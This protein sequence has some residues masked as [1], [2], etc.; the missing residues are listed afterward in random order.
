MA[1]DEQQHQPDTS[2]PSAGRKAEL[3]KQ[4]K[5]Q[6]SITPDSPYKDVVIRTLGEVQWIMTQRGWIGELDLSKGPEQAIANRVN[7]SGATMSDANL[8]GAILSGANLSE[9]NLNRAN[10]SG[11]DLLMANLSS[12]TLRETNLNKTYLGGVNLAEAI[13]YKADLTEAYLGGANLTRVTLRNANLS[14]VTLS[15]ANLTGSHLQDANLSEATLREAN[16]TGIILR[17]AILN[18]VD[19]T[20]SLMDSETVLDGI[21]ID[22]HTKVFGVRWNGAPLD[23]IKW[24]QASLLGDE[25]T[26]EE[27]AVKTANERVTAY[28]NAARAYHGLSVALRGQGLA[29]VASKYRLREL[30]MERKA[31]RYDRN[32]GGWI[33]NMILGV[34]AGYGEK[35][36]RIFISYLVVVLSFAT[37]YFGVTHLVETGLSRLTWDESLVLSLTSFHGRG[38]FPG[39]LSLGD[40]V[41]RI[42]ALEAVIGLFIELILIAT[43][44]RRFLGD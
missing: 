42:A 26:T 6:K 2:E 20:R 28:R 1:N 29:D 14:R 35:P 10:L 8:S 16:L 18:G 37:A 41:S 17:D 12:A 25:P 32:I 22:T 23:S 19:L 36:G 4:Y 5:A 44:S 9:V 21:K 33:L 7:L 27:L 30:V 31:L 11:V 15:E 39:F 43:F 3:E 13:L 34:L 24:D 40:W 38:F